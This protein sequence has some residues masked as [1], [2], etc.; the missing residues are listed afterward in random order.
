M[1]LVLSRTSAVSSR[2]TQGEDQASAVPIDESARVGV[3]IHV[4]FTQVSTRMQS[5]HRHHPLVVTV[6]VRKAN[7]WVVRVPQHA[8]TVWLVSVEHFVTTVSPLYLQ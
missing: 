2:L 3:L 7:T 5:V 4:G 6:I 8:A 1:S